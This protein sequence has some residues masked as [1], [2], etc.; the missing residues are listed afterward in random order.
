MLTLPLQRFKPDQSIVSHQRQ[1]SNECAAVETATAVAKVLFLPE[2]LE[3]ILL[4]LRPQN[5][6]HLQRT[7]KA[8]RDI[9]TESD[10]LQKKLFMKPVHDF[11]EAI[12]L[13]MVE[14]H[15]PIYIT[16]KRND[17]RPEPPERGPLLLNHLVLQY[18]NYN[19][20]T[21]YQN[22]H[23]EY[24]RAY[25]YPTAKKCETDSCRFKLQQA[26]LRDTVSLRRGDSSWEHMLV[27]QP[28]PHTIL[29]RMV[30]I[31]PGK[32][33]PLSETFA[34]LLLIPFRHLQI[35][36]VRRTTFVDG[37]IKLQEGLT[38]TKNRPL[39]PSWTQ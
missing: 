3:A 36:L 29:S 23:Q 9:I 24:T 37:D 7:C 32:T 12:S 33:V 39:E 35:I 26:I 19:P 34:Y 15:H 4:L 28:I 25:M 17:K 18:A 14:P 11:N 38:A 21:V 10:R 27:S 30:S 8:W 2:L 6:L 13:N 31:L 20:G 1:T 5:L 16:R 22:I